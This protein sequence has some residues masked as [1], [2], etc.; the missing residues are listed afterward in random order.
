MEVVIARAMVKF[1][2]R[3]GASIVKRGQSSRNGIA[4]GVQ[5]LSTVPGRNDDRIEVAGGDRVEIQHQI[6]W[7]L[8]LGTVLVREMEA[9]EAR[10]AQR[11]GA[12]QYT[13]A[14]HQPVDDAAHGSTGGELTR[15]T[16]R[17]MVRHVIMQDI[18]TTYQL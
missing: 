8:R 6:G 17:R 4:V 7:S 16:F 1:Q 10:N 9:N 13:P 14:A 3:L 15:V 12:L 2:A 11:N 5:D 18:P